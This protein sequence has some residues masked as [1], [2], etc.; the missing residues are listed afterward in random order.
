MCKPR[1]QEGILQSFVFR[2]HCQ[3]RSSLKLILCHALYLNLTTLIP[4][5]STQTSLIILFSL[6]CTSCVPEE[7]S[8]N[9]KEGTRKGFILSTVKSGFGLKSD[10]E[11]CSY[12]TWMLSAR[13][14]PKCPERKVLLWV[15]WVNEK[16]FVVNYWKASAVQS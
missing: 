6:P 1:D 13:M 14:T 4:F 12:I 2:H 16:S 5:P 7:N 3:Q 15:L 9:Q 10:T 11:S 8:G